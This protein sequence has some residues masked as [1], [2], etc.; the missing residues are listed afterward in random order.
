M[1]SL[2]LKKDNCTR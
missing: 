1:T 2:K